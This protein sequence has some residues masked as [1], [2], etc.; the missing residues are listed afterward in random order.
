MTGDQTGQIVVV[1]G[2]GR[3]PDLL[4][5]ELIDREY[6]VKIL[7]LP[8]FDPDQKFQYLIVD[9]PSLETFTQSL[10]RLHHDGY[11]HIAFAG[12][13][14]RPRQ[15]SDAVAD[16]SGL[17]D[18]RQ[19]D[20]AILKQIVQITEN[21]GFEVIGGHQLVPEL[22]ATPG[23]LGQQ[24]PS[25]EDR[26]DVARAAEIVR[27]IGALDVG[28]AA[29]VVNRQCVAVETAAGTNAMLDFA[30]KTIDRVNPIS[31]HARGIL[32]KA[33][34][35]GQELRIDMPTIGTDTVRHAAASGLSGIAIEAHT[36]LILDRSDV[37][38]AADAHEMFVWARNP[39]E[40]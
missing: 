26:Q 24:S 11:Y 32:Y 39:G 30:A 20:D 37:I 14:R 40:E 8:G 31:D 23:I 27:V 1:A 6:D 17:P 28:Q 10:E 19:G 33:P 38:A 29:V 22:V 21:A 12:A 13:V 18:L 36:V 16:Q 5:G 4:I 2:S 15:S 34:K 7:A 9:S 25:A 35:P 3:Y